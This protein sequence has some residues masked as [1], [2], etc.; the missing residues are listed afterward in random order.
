MTTQKAKARKLRTQGVTFLGWD[1]IV[2]TEVKTFLGNGLGLQE[3]RT[4]SWK[5]LS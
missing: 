5:I 3:I 2:I 1:Y 4:R